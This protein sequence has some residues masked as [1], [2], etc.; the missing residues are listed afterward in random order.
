VFEATLSSEMQTGE[1]IDILLSSDL[2]N[3]H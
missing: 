1:A 3:S 2:E